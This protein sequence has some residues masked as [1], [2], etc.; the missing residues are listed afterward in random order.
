[1]FTHGNAET[2]Q[3]WLNQFEPLRQAGMAVLLLEYPGYGEAA[4]T[5]SLKSIEKVMLQ[6]FDDMAARKDIDAQRIIAHGRSIGGG[7]A[8]LLAAQ[9][10]VAALSFESTFSSLP[11]L[12]SEKGLPG[13]LVL[14]RYDNVAVVQAL[15][16]PVF[17]YHGQQDALIPIAHAQRLLAVAKHGQI[18]TADCGHND[19][20][21]PWAAYLLFLRA[22]ALL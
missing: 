19:C 8:G 11:K 1:M 10:P 2:A 17:I 9:R 4:G 22:N 12:V 13:F 21:R 6:A 20:P 3:L 5:A 7:A 16:V 14:D 15:E 18:F